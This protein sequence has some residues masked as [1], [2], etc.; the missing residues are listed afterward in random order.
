MINI[1]G[2]RVAAMGVWILIV[3]APLHA[4]AAMRPIS[5]PWADSLRSVFSSRQTLRM[6]RVPASLARW[7]SSDYTHGLPTRVDNVIPELRESALSLDEPDHQ[8]RL[9]PLVDAMD[10]TGFTPGL[11]I[12]APESEDPDSDAAVHAVKERIAVV[13]AHARDIAHG[14]DALAVK[15]G[16][17]A[18]ERELDLHLGPQRKFV[19]D[20]IMLDCLL[21][22]PG[23]KKKTPNEVRL[24]NIHRKIGQLRMLIDEKRRKSP[25]AGL[26]GMARAFWN[27]DSESRQRERALALT[28]GLER[29]SL[30]L[31][32]QI[33]QL[34]VRLQSA[35]PTL[36]SA[37]AIAS[38]LGVIISQ[39]R[40]Y[41]SLNELASAELF[42]KRALGFHAL[43]VADAVL[44]SYA[45]RRWVD[46]PT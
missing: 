28:V 3:C 22:L 12:D 2:R 38:E 26:N 42:Q 33:R 20:P 39:Q 1:A 8:L 23:T 46:V 35:N 44:Q 31:E 15:N 9:T 21:P 5:P 11:F 19:V 18:I 37:H 36:E 14:V 43:R 34:I 24:D 13:E 41:V 45:E 7:S 30:F 25:P 40:V 29:A 32:S 4:A 16:L 10:S 27:Y 17:A 6:V